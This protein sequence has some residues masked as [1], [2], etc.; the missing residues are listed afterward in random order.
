M[1]T[2]DTRASGVDTLSS[3]I[4]SR[5]ARLSSAVAESIMIGIS[6]ALNLKMVG[7]DTP[8]GSIWL[9]ISSLSRTLLVAASMSTP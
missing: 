1:P 9:N 6:E 7:I 4:L 8:S 2:P 5:P 3:R